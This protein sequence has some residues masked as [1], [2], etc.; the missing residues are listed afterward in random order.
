MVR[1]RRTDTASI[2]Q[3]TSTIFRKS[4]NEDTEAGLPRPCLCSGEAKPKVKVEGELLLYV[5]D[6]YKGE[7]RQVVR[8]E[9]S[10]RR[11]TKGAPP[12]TELVVPC[13]C[14]LLRG[15]SVVNE[16]SL[17]GESVPQIKETLRAFEDQE[18]GVV[19]LGGEGNSADAV[20]KRHLV[21]GGTA[22]VQ[23]CGDA[24]CGCAD[25]GHAG[26]GGGPC[27]KVL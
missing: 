5:P 16:A 9:A 8:G 26:C 19:Q 23:G 1:A 10:Q 12:K 25:C 22:L 4:Q 11:R 24:G 15:S 20:W 6:V 21:Y 27:T 3:S 7:A 18:G 2:H 14:V 17:T 13:D